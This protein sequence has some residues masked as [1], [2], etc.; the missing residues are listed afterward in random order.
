MNRRCRRGWA[1]HR[2]TQCPA[3]GFSRADHNPFV[4]LRIEI[5]SRLECR[6]TCDPAECDRYCSDEKPKPAEG[7][8][9]AFAR[10]TIYLDAETGYQVG[11]RLTRADGELVGSYFFRDITFNPVFPAGQFTTVAFK[12]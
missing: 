2:Q 3:V 11:A 6:P 5:R 8:P 9:D 4:W 12:K 1:S 10:A 7:A